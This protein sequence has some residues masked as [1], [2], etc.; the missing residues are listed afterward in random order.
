MNFCAASEA[1]ACG[2]DR[3]LRASSRHAQAAAQLAV[4]LQHQFD[5]SSCTS[6]ASSGSGQAR[7]R[8]SSP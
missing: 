5:S 2:L 6:A 3:V 1:S 4:D 8:M 7:G